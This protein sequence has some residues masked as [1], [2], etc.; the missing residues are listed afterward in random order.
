ME[1]H[2]LCVRIL[3]APIPRSSTTRTSNEHSNL[4]RTDL[5]SVEAVC[6]LF[7]EEQRDR[8]DWRLLKFFARNRVAQEIRNFEDHVQANKDND[9]DWRR[10]W[11]DPFERLC[12]EQLDK[13]LASGRLYGGHDGSSERITREDLV[14]TW[15]RLS[16]NIIKYYKKN[17]FASPINLISI[18]I[19]PE[20]RKSIFSFNANDRRNRTG[21]SRGGIGE[22]ERERE[23]EREC[24]RERERERAKKRNIFL[25]RSISIE[26]TFSRGVIRFWSIVVPPRSRRFSVPPMENTFPLTQI[27][28]GRTK[29]C[30]KWKNAARPPTREH[31]STKNNYYGKCEATTSLLE[32]FQLNTYS[33][34][35]KSIASATR[36][37]GRLESV[38]SL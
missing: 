28:L 25:E 8:T 30:G 15:Y 18:N 5:M 6:R 4:R 16:I 3:V 29:R 35:R 32:K 27:R 12:F 22:R 19:I 34:R 20:A 14:C 17:D 21:W 7:T 10:G 11:N 1:K 31:Q 26:W 2:S 38:R 36:K 24:A 13:S 33:E 23:R 37:G 9:R